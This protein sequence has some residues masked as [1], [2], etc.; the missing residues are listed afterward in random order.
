MTQ[1]NAFVARKKPTSIVKTAVFFQAYVAYWLIYLDL[2]LR[3]SV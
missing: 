3:M 1:L 2:D